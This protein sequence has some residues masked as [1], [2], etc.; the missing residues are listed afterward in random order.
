MKGYFRVNE[1]PL[2]QIYFYLTEGC[3]LR[4]RHCWINPKYQAGASIYPSLDLKLFQHIITQAK[5][6]GLT[7]VK[8]TGGEPLLHP[9]IHTILDIVRSEDLRLVIETNG[10]RCT[11]EIADKITDCNKPFV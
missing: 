3:D 2:N 10:M 7:G 11:P 5:D 4:C 8:L 1:Y 9:N 6:L